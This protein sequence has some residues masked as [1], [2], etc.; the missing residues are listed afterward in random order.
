VHYSWAVERTS[1]F[2]Y[3]SAYLWLDAND[4]GTLGADEVLYASPPLATINA[5]ITGDFV[6]PAG[7]LTSRP[8]RL[9]ILWHGMRLNTPPAVPP[10]AHVRDEDYDQ[11]R[12]FTVWVSSTPLA[13]K[14]P[15]GASLN[16][17]LVYPNPSTG[18][19]T[20]SGTGMRSA[21]QLEV[22]SVLGQ[23][24]SR[25]LLSPTPNG[26]YVADLSR[27]PKGLYALRVEGMAQMQR[28]VVN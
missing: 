27:L 12:D 17:W 26:D 11:I 5:R 7:A 6:V 15:V 10:D 3:N 21:R 22:C 20:I 23:V 14:L 8:L 19:I 16:S 18:W 4:D 24:V 2:I 25:H 9:R 1:R 28:L 13:V